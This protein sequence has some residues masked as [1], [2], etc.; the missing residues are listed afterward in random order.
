MEAA[1]RVLEAV[2]EAR[3]GG[4]TP[5]DGAG[6]GTP[7]AASASKESQL[8]A[9]NN[10]L[11]AENNRLK[12]QALQDA[13]KIRELDSSL[14]DR[15][16][17]LLVAQRKILQLKENSVVGT[18]TN[19]PTNAAAASSP[20]GPPSQQQPSTSQQDQGNSSALVAELENVKRLLQ[21]R[22]AEVEERDGSLSKSER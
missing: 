5:K 11:K 13:T 6:A 17:E 15:E 9:M 21:R 14:A 22:E 7:T 1:T 10:L 18:T 20:V 2:E 4:L 8:A 19:I 16:E 3:G 12:D